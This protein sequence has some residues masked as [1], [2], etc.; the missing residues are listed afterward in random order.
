MKS[1]S[2]TSSVKATVTWYGHSAFL[3]QAPGGVGVLVDPWL[4]N[5][6]SPRGAVSGVDPGLILVTHGH[7][8]HLGNTVQVALR[9]G[10]VVVSIHEVCLYLRGKGVATAQGM[11]KGG[12][13]E[14]KGIKV[15]MVDARH[16][17]GIDIEDEVVP[18]GEAAGFVVE[19]ENGFRIY[20]AGDTS[21]FGDMK[22]IR[23]FHHPDVAILP[24]GGLYTMDP[25][26]AALACR[27]LLPR[28]IIGMH[29]GTFP[30]L[31]GSPSELK[32]FLPSELRRRVMKLEPGVAV[33]LG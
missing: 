19:L 5:P 7:A 27:M 20:H 9:T 30:A 11:N 14:C 26:Q 1:T 3:L 32:R 23:D 21:L 16:S 33:Q 29:Y 10:A 24:I 22:L 8:D 31:A 25:T 6:K 28:H 18:G 15:S 17:S 12:T 2:K 13:V 4:D